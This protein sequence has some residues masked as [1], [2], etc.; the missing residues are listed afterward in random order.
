MRVV[1]QRVKH[2]SV[3]VE[4]KTTGQIQDGFML[5]VGIK[6]DDTKEII[7]KLAKKVSELRI[8]SDEAGKM[9]LSIQDI[10]GS[11]LSISQFTLYADCKRGRRPGFELAEKPQKAN[12]MYEYFNSILRNYGIIVETGVFGA[13]MQVELCND[14]PVTIILDSDEL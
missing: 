9:N 4:G 13:D 10:K 6:K 11:I 7:E 5:L 8:F 1:I 2:A 3:T 14:G 12:E